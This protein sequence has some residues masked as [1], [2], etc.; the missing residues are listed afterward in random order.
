MFKISLLLLVTL[1]HAP[2]THPHCKRARAVREGAFVLEELQVHF[3][4]V[5]L[6][7]KGGGEIRLALVSGAHQ[8][9]LQ[10]GVFPFVMPQRVCL[11]EHLLAHRARERG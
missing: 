3:A 10:G 9:R 1:A 4:D 11:L 5:V 6:Q 8:H 7:V 2:S